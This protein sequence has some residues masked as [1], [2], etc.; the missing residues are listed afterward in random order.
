[1]HGEFL[2]FPRAGAGEDAK[3]SKSSGEFITLQTLI[4]RGFDPPVYRY[5]CL[6]AHYRAQLAF[7]WEALGA[8]AS[9]FG[10]LKRLVPEL[11]KQATGEERPIEQTLR[12][13]NEA[14]EDDL[15][16]PRALAA[17]WSAVKNEQAERGEVYATLLEMDQV[18]GL[19]FE[20][21]TEQPLPIPEAEIE[22]LVEQRNAARKSKDFA[23]ADEIRDRLAALGI[24]LEDGPGGTPWRSG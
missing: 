13:F 20:Q 12:E 1:M 10:R 14:V 9:A 4:E 23:K 8:A 24:A 2:T 18:L 19:G 11:R 15:N 22:E 7:T 6:N 5:F 3:M 17:M 16:T 21:M